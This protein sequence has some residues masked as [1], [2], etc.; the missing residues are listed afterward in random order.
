MDQNTTDLVLKAQEAILDDRRTKEH[1]I[2]ILDDNGVITLKGSVPSQAEKEIAE[3]IIEKVQ[4]VAGVI[5]E[6]EVRQATD[7][8]MD[9]LGTNR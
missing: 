2:E 9:T 7:M 3:K 8:P 5:N 1:G 4:G 6:L